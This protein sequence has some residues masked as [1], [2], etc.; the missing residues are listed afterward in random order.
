MYLCR[1]HADWSLYCGVGLGCHGGRYPFSLSLFTAAAQGGRC[2]RKV[3]ATSAAAAAAGTAVAAAAA[4]AV[5]AE[6]AARQ[7]AL[8]APQ[9]LRCGR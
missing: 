8:S 6:A 9:W 1:R 2:G 5:M 4:R 7:A 3:V